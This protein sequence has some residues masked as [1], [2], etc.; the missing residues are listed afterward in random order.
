MYVRNEVYPRNFVRLQRACQRGIVENSEQMHISE[1]T[2]LRSDRTT[3]SGGNERVDDETGRCVNLR[4]NE[5]PDRSAALDSP[6]RYA[7]Q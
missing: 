5:N 2:A 4:A 3:P 6:E 1:F 7:R